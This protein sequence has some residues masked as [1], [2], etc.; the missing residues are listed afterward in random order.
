MIYI[1]KGK[2]SKYINNISLPDFTNIEHSHT[3]Y[4]ILADLNLP[5]YITTNYDH[6]ME[7]VLR[8]RGKN[9]VSEFCRWNESLQDY[10]RSMKIPSVFDKGSRYNVNPSTP[11]VY[12][13]YGDFTIP[14]SMVL[15][16]K[17][18]FDFITNLSREDEKLLLPSV[19]RRS[20]VTSSL[21]FIGYKMEDIKFNSIFLSI[22]NYKGIRYLPNIVIFD[23]L[24]T[25]SNNKIEKANEFLEKYTKKIFNAYVILDNV[26]EFSEVLR[27]KWEEFKRN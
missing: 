9:P 12:H 7:E 27:I 6:I 1:Q 10:V 15:T 8:S 4:G 25:V 13:L 19:I 26:S 17:D 22:L 23:P 14:Q 18:Y 2:L 11:L 20:L 16:T 5:I 21:L 3:I 24:E